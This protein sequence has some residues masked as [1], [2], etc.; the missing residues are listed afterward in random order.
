[1]SDNFAQTI[2]K[3]MT[4]ERNILRNSF[5][6]MTLGLT[7]TGIIAFAVSGNIP[8]LRVLLKPFLFYGLVIG[9]LALVWFLSS[10]VLK[11][12]PGMAVGSFIGYAG[13]NGVTLSVIF[14]VYTHSSIVSVFFIAAGM[15]AC[16]AVLGYTT[17]VDLTKMGTYL[18]MGVIGILIASV[19]NIFLRSDFVS[20]IISIVGVV[21]F[22][23]LTAF[24]VQKIKNI[25]AAHG[26]DVSEPQYLRLSIYG[27][28]QL[29]LDFINLFLHLLR[30]LGR[31]R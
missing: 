12:S 6:W 25:S 3:P 31:R 23:G 10:Q 9:E 27:A 22:A 21:V 15:F 1:M 4:M 7:F 26:S 20:W 11:M 8:L 2:A 28:L 14:L 19:V 13:L 18:V 24:D 30:L 16:L 5:L 29:Y 17:K